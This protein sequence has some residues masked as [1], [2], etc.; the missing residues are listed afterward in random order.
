MRKI[1]AVIPARAAS[2]GI[3]NKNIRIINGYPLIYYAIQNAKKSKYI[4]DIIVSTDSP[5]VR[6][7]A[8]QTG[9][10]C[11][12]RDARLCEDHITLDSVIFDAISNG[13]YDYVVTMQPTSP[14][15]KVETLDSAIAYSIDN[16]I[17]TVISGKN[18]PH[19][20]WSE[21]DGKKIPN[22]KQRLNRQYLPSYFIETG[23]FVISKASIVTEKTR[24]GKTV[25]IF[26][27]SEAEAIDIDSFSDLRNATFVLKDEKA[28]IY[29]NGNNKRGIGHIYRALELADGQGHSYRGR[30]HRRLLRGRQQ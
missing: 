30:S 27:I 16:D 23:A 13:E 5:E 12:W 22:Y 2:K 20:S 25:D 21:R 15:L 10:K 18:S 26:E 28:A 4:T 9:V 8:K 6:I 29:V 3:P 1:V 11:H 14:T 19:L 17:D 7:I 24:I